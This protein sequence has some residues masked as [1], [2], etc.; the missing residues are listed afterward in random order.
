MYR[1]QPSVGLHTDPCAQTRPIARSF[2]RSRP[3]KLP[4]DRIPSEEMELSDLMGR[5]LVR[6]VASWNEREIWSLIVEQ[7]STAMRLRQKVAAV[8]VSSLGLVGW[9]CGGDEV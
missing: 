3:R 8:L 7:E 6:M 4:S 5:P 1:V 2:R 9:G